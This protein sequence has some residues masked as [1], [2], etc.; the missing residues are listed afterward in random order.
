MIKEVF[1]YDLFLRIFDSI[2]D[3]GYNPT[4]QSNGLMDELDRIMEL[5]KQFVSIGDGILLDMHYVSKGVKNFYDVDQE[6]VSFGWY[7]KTSHPDDYARRIAVRSRIFS[8]AQNIYSQKKGAS[9][10]SSNFRCMTRSGEYKNILH[11]LLLF[12]AEMPYESVFIIMVQTDLSDFKKIQKGIHIYI[13]DDQSNF[14]CPD[15]E[16]LMM[17]NK[18]S[19]T[20]FKIIQLIN[21]GLSTKEIAQKLFRSHFTISTHRSNII[22]K[23]G[24]ETIFDVIKDLKSQAL[25]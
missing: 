7:L 20:E 11:Q 16:L 10:V 6:K 18:Y 17:G 19:A 5:N 21:D 2:S 14:R 9:V 22:K 3:A 25:L 4:D 24:R 12:Y 15:D 8:I 23:S 13:G 1:D